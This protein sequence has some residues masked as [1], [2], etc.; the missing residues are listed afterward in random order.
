MIILVSNIGHM[1]W[2]HEVNVDSLGNGNTFACF[3]I[4][5]TLLDFSQV[6]NIFVIM[7]AISNANSFQNQ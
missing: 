2:L 7:G 1:N 4:L 3:H 6:L 5:K